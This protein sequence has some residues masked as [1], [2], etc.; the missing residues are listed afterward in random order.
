MAI[1]ETVFCG[2][3]SDSRYPRKVHLLDRD[4]EQPLCGQ[5]IPHQE[6][7][8]CSEIDEV[9]YVGDEACAKCLKKKSSLSP[10]APT[11]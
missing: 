10:S 7:V 8:E 3:T 9:N 5:H 2:G 6:L 1:L 11:N 4:A